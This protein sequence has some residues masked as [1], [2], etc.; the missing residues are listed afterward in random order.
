ML[1]NSCQRINTYLSI[2]N[3]LKHFNEGIIIRLC[4]VYIIG[5]CTNVKV[6]LSGYNNR[7][8]FTYH[9]RQ[10]SCRYSLEDLEG[11]P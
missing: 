5:N 8:T 4:C 6:D 7:P 10:T 9:V 11:R 3:L 2:K 1:Y